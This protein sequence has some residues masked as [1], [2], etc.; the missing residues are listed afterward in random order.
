MTEICIS[1]WNELQDRLFQDAW[2]PE[3]KRFRSPFV[4]RG[5]DDAAYGLATSLSRLGHNFQDL[6]PHLLRNFRKYAQLNNRYRAGHCLDNL[7]GRLNVPLPISK[8]EVQMAGQQRFKI[9]AGQVLDRGQR[10]GHTTIIGILPDNLA[11]KKDGV[12]AYQVTFV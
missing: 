1:S 4:F 3:L 2:R 8:T 6:E 9:V 11:A 10:I 5:V 12:S 7:T